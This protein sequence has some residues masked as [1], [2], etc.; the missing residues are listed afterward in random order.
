[1]YL[2]Q[3][4]LKRYSFSIQPFKITETLH[5][6]IIMRTQESGLLQLNKNVGVLKPSKV[7]SHLFPLA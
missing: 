2:P 6:W 1:M 3:R 7:S 4:A 5:N